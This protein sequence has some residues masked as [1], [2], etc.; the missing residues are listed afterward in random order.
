MRPI[1]ALHFLIPI[2]LL[3]VSARPVEAQQDCYVRS[4]IRA[5]VNA[6]T[7]TPDTDVRVDTNP[8]LVAPAIAVAHAFE[9]NGPDGANGDS[10]ATVTASYG[11][12]RA[13]GSCQATNSPSSGAF[14]LLTSFIG[15]VPRAAFTDRLHLTHPGGQT[16]EVRLTRHLSATNTLTSLSAGPLNPSGGLGVHFD[17]SGVNT[18]LPPIGYGPGQTNT[19]TVTIIRVASGQDLTIYARLDYELECNANQTA[20]AYHAEGSARA[21]ADVLL[22]VLTPDAVVTS[23]SG[24]NYVPVVPDA[25]VPIDTGVAEDTGE[26]DARVASD[27]MAAGDVGEPDAGALPDVGTA[28]AD[29][30]VPPDAGTL[31]DVGAA[32]GGDAAPSTGGCTCQSSASGPG[33]GLA[34]F[35]GLLFGASFLRRRQM[36]RMRRVSSLRPA[37]KSC[38]E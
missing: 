8:Q 2:A 4:H 9:R 6:N 17:I 30:T 7:I 38:L 33:E 26:A 10:T 15:A 21:T 16:I 24:T 28:A 27:A 31:A 36:I 13:L 29:A 12:M 18:D 34:L 5:V 22:E 32:T 14:T 35:A 3:G 19:T 11:S 25:G 20:P 1:A 37:S 23:C